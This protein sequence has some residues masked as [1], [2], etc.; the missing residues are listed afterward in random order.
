MTNFKTNK[1]KMGTS[2]FNQVEHVSPFPPS[3][4]DDD[5]DGDDDDDD[6]V[7]LHVPEC[8]LT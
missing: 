3:D 2:N 8:R 7:E 5:D 6:D 1:S 4:D